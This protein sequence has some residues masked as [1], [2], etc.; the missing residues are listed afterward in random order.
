MTSQIAPDSEVYTLQMH[1][2]VYMTLCSCRLAEQNSLRMFII[3]TSC[4]LNLAYGPPRLLQTDI[5]ILYRVY[6]LISI[7]R[8]KT[9]YE[10]YLDTRLIVGIPFY[11]HVYCTNRSYWS[12]YWPFAND[13]F[14]SIMSSCQFKMTLKFFHLNDSETQPQRGDPDYTQ[15]GHF[16]T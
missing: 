1:A 9:C 2:V 8:S 6:L 16:L 12:K 15:C 10:Q 5:C 11:R 7:E 13:N 3:P 14:S 4:N